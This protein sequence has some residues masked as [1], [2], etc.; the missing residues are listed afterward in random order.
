MLGQCSRRVGK[1]G[2]GGTAVLFFGEI[3]SLAPRRCGVGDGGGVMKHMLATILGE[4]DVADDEE[5]GDGELVGRVV[6]IGATNR[7]DLLD[8][9]LLRLRRFDWLVY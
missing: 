5:G 1:G 2:C 7:P 3:D 6:V 9:L 4:L 8:P